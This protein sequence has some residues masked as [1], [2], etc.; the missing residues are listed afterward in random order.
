MKLNHKINH[1][2]QRPPEPINA[3]YQRE[4]D[5]SVSK[6]ETK[7]RQA[8]KAVQRAEKAAARAELRAARR[9]SP[10]TIAARDEARRLVL[11]R[12]DELRQIEELM[13]TPT[14]T[15]TVAV[16]RTGRQDR[17]EVGEYRKPRKKKT[18]KNPVKTTRRNP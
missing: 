14:H 3:L 2:W 5:R 1:G 13:R 12:L 16:H 6:A 9:P 8:Q 15:P 17:L 10:E 11:Q 18:P 7:W 4:I